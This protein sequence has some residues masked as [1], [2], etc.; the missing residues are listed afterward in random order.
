M[1]GDFSHPLQMNASSVSSTSSNAMRLPLPGTM[2]AGLYSHGAFSSHPHLN[3]PPLSIGIQQ[4][5]Q[6]RSSRAVSPAPSSPRTSISSSVPLDFTTSSPGSRHPLRSSTPINNDKL[7]DKSSSADSLSPTET[8]E[9][10]QEKSN[11]RLYDS[12]PSPP[13]KPIPHPALSVPA[14]AASSFHPMAG[15]GALRGNMPPNAAAA[16]AAAAAMSHM[17]Y[18]RLWAPWMA[19]G[20]AFFNPYA[21]AGLQNC[22]IP[23]PGQMP[24]P[25]ACPM[26]THPESKAAGLATE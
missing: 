5:Q 26:P 21:A 9:S 16:A 24:L 13:E 3:M 19:S 7:S 11:G 10:G 22:V 25:G 1:P 23:R 17:D 4:Q 2:P 6:D 20:M 12:A 14:M 15:G 18:A 8:N